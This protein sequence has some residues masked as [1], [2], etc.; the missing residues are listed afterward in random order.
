MAT[1]RLLPAGRGA[2]VEGLSDGRFEGGSK[3]TE[4]N[5]ANDGH[6]PQLEDGPS[7]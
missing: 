5:D 1:G 7:P 4:A 6:K 3:S 2:T